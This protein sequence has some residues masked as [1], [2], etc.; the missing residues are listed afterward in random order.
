MA[1]KNLDI[2]SAIL[3]SVKILFEILHGVEETARS[4]VDGLVDGKGGREV[5]AVAVEQEYD[6]FHLADLDQADELFREFAA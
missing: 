6:L 1:I 2:D 5:I 4:C 3:Q